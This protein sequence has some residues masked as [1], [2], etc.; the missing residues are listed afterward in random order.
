MIFTER[1][2]KV[3]N[4]SATV[5]MPVILYRGDRKIEV[6]FEILDSKFKFD[7]GTNLIDATK[8]TYAQLAILNPNGS[9]AFTEI[10]E[11][12]NGVVIFTITGEMID[13]LDE[14]GFYSFHIRLYD[15]TKESR[16]SLPPIEKGIDI[17]EPITSEDNDPVG[18]AMVGYTAVSDKD[19]TD[20]PAFDDDNNY[21][22]T[23]WETGDI[24]SKYKLNKI[25]EAIDVINQKEAGTSGGGISESS[26]LTKHIADGQVTAQKTDFLTNTEITIDLGA[27][28]AGHILADGSIKNSGWWTTDFLPVYKD[29]K[30]IITGTTKFFM[31]YDRDKV[32][33]PTSYSDT[34]VFDERTFTP[35]LDGYVRF[36]VTDAEGNDAYQPLNEVSISSDSNILKFKYPVVLEST[37]G[38]QGVGSFW[39]NR[40]FISLGDSITWQDGNV[41]SSGPQK[42]KV[43]RGY[44]TILKE[45]LN[46]DS[47][48]N[49]GYSGRAVS[50][51]NGKG[52]NTQCKSLSYTGYDLLT[53][54]GGTNDFKLINNSSAY[55]YS[56]LLST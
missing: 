43:A 24:I 31:L 21:N 33:I 19:E 32:A 12:E 30:Y 35:E 5:D 9:N 51:C 56:L 37:G 40:K 13:E 22:K 20:M 11:T 2:V 10:T 36:S 53:I 45:T 14:V 50:N 54:F 25:E 29:V 1:T 55:R 42:D 15:K 17:R 46:F 3:S 6:K 39:S 44:Q 52:I 23:T 18:M 7:K 38:I 27:F 8:A 34:V 47:Y 4:G 28:S 49:G 16:I 26:I 48:V 41:Y